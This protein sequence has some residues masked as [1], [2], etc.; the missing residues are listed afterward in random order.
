MD[1]MVFLLWHLV[2][3]RSI[4]MA[5]EFEESNASNTINFITTVQTR[6]LQHGMS[7]MPVQQQLLLISNVFALPLPPSLSQFRLRWLQ[8]VQDR[9]SRS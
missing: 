1:S 3:E 6:P 2:F 4:I 9:G 8:S 7:W 5:N